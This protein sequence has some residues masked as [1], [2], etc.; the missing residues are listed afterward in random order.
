MTTLNLQ[1]SA[2]SD[3]AIEN[4][5]GSV[6]LTGTTMVF[7]N[8]AFW[9]G[10]RFLSVTIP[11]GSTINSATLQYYVVNT[12]RDDNEHDVYGQAADNA[13]TFTTTTNDISSRTRTTAKV[14]VTADAVGVG[15]YSVT[16]LAGVVQEI[17]DRA[18]WV[19]GN[20]L[21]LIMD[22][23]V[24]PNLGPDTWD[25]NPAQAAKLDIDYTAPSA[26]EI[27]ARYEIFTPGVMVFSPGQ[28]QI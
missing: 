14:T 4:A 21:A 12:S 11:Q 15:F 8:A 10:Y 13:G 25:N 22:A 28:A 20:A 5:S 6:T 7:N 23:L 26:G 9:I 18:G 17:T 16:G 19:S 3:D 24:T 27:G 1:V 2:S